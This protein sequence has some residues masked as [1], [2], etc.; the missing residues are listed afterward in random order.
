MNKT[1][2]VI[3]LLMLFTLVSIF[4]ITASTIENVSNVCICDEVEGVHVISQYDWFVR[5]YKIVSICD[6]CGLPVE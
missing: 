5:E 6:E 4:C 3:L 2:V 1:G